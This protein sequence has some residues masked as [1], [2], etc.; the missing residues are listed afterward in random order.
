MAKDGVRGGGTARVD[1]NRNRR[2]VRRL[3][4]FNENHAYR[5]LSAAIV[6]RKS[7]KPLVKS[8]PFGGSEPLSEPRSVSTCARLKRLNLYPLTQKLPAWCNFAKF[9]ETTILRRINVATR[10]P[11]CGNSPRKH[12]VNMPVTRS[13]CEARGFQRETCP[14]SGY[15]LVKFPL[16]TAIPVG[17][18]H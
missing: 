9:E 18:S 17:K 14:A 1:V 12:V 10:G 16:G 2:E 7:R 4:S 15:S 11:R 6:K 5:A 13:S 3:L 8:A